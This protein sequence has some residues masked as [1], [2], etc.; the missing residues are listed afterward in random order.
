MICLP[1]EAQTQINQVFYDF[2]S[3][4]QEAYQNVTSSSALQETYDT[5]LNVCKQ[6]FETIKNYWININPAYKQVFDNTISVAQKAAEQRAASQSHLQ[7]QA[8]Q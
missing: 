7:E 3:G 4:I 1:Q 5:L 8:A 6:R 2:T